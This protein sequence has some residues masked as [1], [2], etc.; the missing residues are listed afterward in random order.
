MHCLAVAR[1]WRRPN[2]AAAVVV[3][4]V[5]P[6]LRG[7]G[8][9]GATPRHA[10]QPRS[11]ASVS[12]SCSSGH[13]KSTTTLRWPPLR[14]GG[15]NDCCVRRPRCREAGASPRHAAKPRSHASVSCSGGSRKSAAT[16]RRSLL[17]GDGGRHC[18]QCAWRPRYGKAGATPWHAA[19]HPPIK[20]IPIEV[21]VSKLAQFGLE[22]S[23]AALVAEGV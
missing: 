7:F 1:R 9:A 3:R 19:K 12:C 8:E 5:R 20:Y 13:R 23:T 2:S 4:G 21:H 15:S 17:R 14:G 16:L 22:R 6:P 18:C 10:A 11:H